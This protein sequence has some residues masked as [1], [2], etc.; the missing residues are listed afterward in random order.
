LATRNS[1]HTLTVFI[2]NHSM[3]SICEEQVA[4]PDN[5]NSAQSATTNNVVS[6]K[7]E[8]S[9]TNEKKKRHGMI[10]ICTIGRVIIGNSLNNPPRSN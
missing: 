8:P 2:Y 5:N 10:L 6:I 7:L 4:T 1:V 9:K 3:Q